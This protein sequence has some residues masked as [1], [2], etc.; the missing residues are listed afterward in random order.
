[1]NLYNID[2]I[3]IPESMCQIII[4]FAFI[5]RRNTIKTMADAMPNKVNPVGMNPR[6]LIS[7]RDVWRMFSVKRV[8]MINPANWMR[9]IIA[10]MII[11]TQISLG[12][13]A[14]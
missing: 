3:Q 7:A 13:F 9:A 12:L 10:S 14:I 11:N 6:V 4:D 2:S 1:M 5:F 8:S